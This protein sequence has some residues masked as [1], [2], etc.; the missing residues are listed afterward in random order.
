M[1]LIFFFFLQIVIKGENVANAIVDIRADTK[2]DAILSI[3][4]TIFVSVI[5]AG[6][7]MFLSKNVEDILVSKIE[8]MYKIIKKISKNPLKAAQMEEKEAFAIEKLR[9]EGHLKELAVLHE[10]EKM[11]TSILEKLIVKLGALLSVGFG[12]AG[13]EI[14]AENIK[15]GGSVNPLIPGKK[16][17]AIFGFCD[18]RNFLEVTEVL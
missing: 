14:I 9:Q 4:R 3:I 10:E 17:L 16:I 12:E 7:S 13:S 18:I 15:K 2:L 11:E 5:L 1:Y 8:T 6:G